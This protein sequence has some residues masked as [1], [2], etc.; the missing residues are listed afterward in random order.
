MNRATGYEP[1]NAGL[2]PVGEAILEEIY[3]AENGARIFVGDDL[4]YE[5]IKDKP[6]WKSCRMCKYGAGGHQQTLGYTTLG[7]PKGKHYLSIEKGDHMA[8]NIIDMDDPNMIPWKCITDA[9]TYVK[10]QMDE[11]YHVLIACNSGHSRGPTT[12]LMFL[13]AI[14]ELPYHFVKAE[15]VYRALY[16]KYDPGMGMRQTARSR[17]SELD[18]MENK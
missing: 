14:G 9:L 3:R 10:K 16:P 7:A 8:I 17:W 4:D 18:N 6:N 15:Q 12:G 1:V 13:R 2:S 5:K 11:G